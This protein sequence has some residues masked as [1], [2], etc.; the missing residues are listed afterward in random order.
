MFPR[1]CRALPKK[2]EALFRSTV[3]R[4]FFI[5]TI[6]EKQGNFETRYDIFT[7]LLKD[8]IV[9]VMGPVQDEMAAVVVAQLLF[10]NMD[11]AHAPVKMYI[12]SPGGVIT[13]GM[14]IYDCMQLISN[15]I[16]TTCVGQAASMGSVLLTA[17]TPGLR[18]A[19]PNS[20]VMIHQPL[21]GAQG[22]ASD[23]MIQ[24]EEI[25]KTKERLT[26]IYVTHNTKGKTN[27]EF[28]TAL[29]RNNWMTAD[30]AVDFGLI[31]T[32]PSMTVPKP[33]IQTEE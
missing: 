27:E 30:E 25:I 11:D 10:L 13:S 22:Q 19:L 6:I 2:S 8:R 5:P 33:R 20:K 12:N 16:E 23:I 15:P 26:D 3:K 32:V 31:D 21:G 18:S 28:V 24:A 1:I 4:S 17:G 29:D 7:R 14:A 9:C